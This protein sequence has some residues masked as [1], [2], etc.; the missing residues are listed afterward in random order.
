MPPFDHFHRHDDQQQGSKEKD[1]H[2]PARHG[3]DLPQECPDPPALLR[4]DQQ[5][6]LERMLPGTVH[7]GVLSEPPREPS[8]SSVGGPEMG[9]SRFPSLRQDHRVNTFPA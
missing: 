7:A 1:E 4:H 2:E 5:P 9:R 8:A 3:E 6:L